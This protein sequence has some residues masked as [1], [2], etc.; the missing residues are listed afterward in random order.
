MSL[1]FQWRRV[2]RIQSLKPARYFNG[3]VAIGDNEDAKVGL[4]RVVDEAHWTAEALAVEVVLVLLSPGVLFVISVEV[5]K[6][7]RADAP[8]DAKQFAMVA[9]GLGDNLA[10]VLVEELALTKI[11]RAARICQTSS[12]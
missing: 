5:V 10:A 8:A 7:E 12:A 2:K 1:Q 11:A 3:S 6:A 4:V 9:L